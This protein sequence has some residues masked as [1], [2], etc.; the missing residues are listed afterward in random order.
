MQITFSNFQ[1]YKGV[2]AGNYAQPRFL[3]DQDLVLCTYETLRKE[4]NFVDL[5]H[6]DR[7]KILFFQLDQVIKLIFYYKGLRK[8]KRFMTTPSPLTAVNWWRVKIHYS[9][10]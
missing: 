10:P 9:H 7:K 6:S 3:A 2:D 8:P 5:P 1:I 4:L